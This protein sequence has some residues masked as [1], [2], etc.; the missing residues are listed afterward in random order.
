MSQLSNHTHTLER[1]HP[2]MIP[3]M[4]G[5]VAVI[6]VFLIGIRP[7]HIVSEKEAYH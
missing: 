6:L 3:Q 7:L 5:C 4:S 2:G 1:G